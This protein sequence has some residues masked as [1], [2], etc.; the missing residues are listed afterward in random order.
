MT[1]QNYA[2]GELLSET[3]GSGTPQAATWTFG[4]DPTTAGDDEGD[5]PQRQHHQVDV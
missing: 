5:R 1:V 3:K 2:F 4:Y